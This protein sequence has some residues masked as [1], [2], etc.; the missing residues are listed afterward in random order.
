MDGDKFKQRAGVEMLLGY[1]RGAKH[2]SFASRDKLLDWVMQ[3]LPKYY[4]LIKPDTRTLWD[5]FFHVVHSNLV[6][7]WSLILLLQL[8][9]M[10]RDPRRLR[11]ILDWIFSL[12]ID[13]K[14]DSA[15]AGKPNI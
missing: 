1:L 8:I 11:P 6:Y 13:F 5:S 14:G 10:D 3:R 4:S 12:H 9:S 2:W 7:I 15:F